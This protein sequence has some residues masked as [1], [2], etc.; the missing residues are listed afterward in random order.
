M[1]F[2]ILGSFTLAGVS[3]VLVDFGFEVFRL[4]GLVAG[5]V[6][7]L[8]FLLHLFLCFKLGTKNYCNNIY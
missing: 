5:L 4:D 2:D 3:Y 7:V 1:V 8:H 6:V